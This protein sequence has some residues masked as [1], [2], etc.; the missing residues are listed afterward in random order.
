MNENFKKKYGL[1][2]NVDTWSAHGQEIITMAGIYKIVDYHDI[3]FHFGD[4]LDISPAVALRVVAFMEVEGKQ[5]EEIMFGE[6]NANN[7]KVNYYWAMALNRG[8]ARATL[9]LLGVYGKKGY[10]MEDEAEVFEKKSPTI[11]QI[12][13]YTKLLKDCRDKGLISMTG[14]TYFKEND[15]EIRNNLIL[16][17]NVIDKLKIKIKDDKNVS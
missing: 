14:D 17:T 6:A 2:S 3:R 15:K 12:E 16:W 11:K 7:C 4:N 10:Y 1:V 13:Q 9:M 5:K 8:K